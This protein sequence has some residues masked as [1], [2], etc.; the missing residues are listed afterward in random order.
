MVGIK[1]DALD[2]VLI[3]SIFEPVIDQMLSPSAARK[4]ILYMEN[5]CAEIDLDATRL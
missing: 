3:Q 4:P 2:K 5:H 1:Q